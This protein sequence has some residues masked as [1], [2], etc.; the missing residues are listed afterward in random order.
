[1]MRRASKG[2][3]V[4]ALSPL[5]KFLR[6]ERPAGNLLRRDART[7]N[8]LRLEALEDRTVPTFTISSFTG[9]VLTLVNN[10]SGVNDQLTFDVN[11]T[12]VRA[13]VNG[14]MADTG[15]EIDNTNGN[16][17]VQVLVDATDADAPTTIDLT[18]LPQA[19]QGSVD[20]SFMNAGAVLTGSS[21]ADS[22]FGYL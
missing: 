21:F 17:L 1:M 2:F 4:S 12:S 14:V 7:Q 3:W 19:G 16:L 11:G 9:G 10:S 15:A 8:L 6:R 20:P 22:I 5:R 13:N 18:G